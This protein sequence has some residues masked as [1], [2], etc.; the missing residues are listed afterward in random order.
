LET[1]IKTREFEVEPD[2]KEIILKKTSKIKKHFPDAQKLEVE[3]SQENNPSIANPTGVELTLSVKKQL[4]RAESHGDNLVTALDKAVQK[5]N[6]QLEKH[7]AK[8][9]RSNVNHNKIQKMKIENAERT[10]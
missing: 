5:I 8:L 7:K 9:Y 10:E 3:I 4:L 1:L 2:F 6:R